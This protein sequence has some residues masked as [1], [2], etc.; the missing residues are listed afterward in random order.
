M[1]KPFLGASQLVVNHLGLKC[2]LRSRA[3]ARACAREGRG[4]YRGPLPADPAHVNGAATPEI[5]SREEP[6]RPNAD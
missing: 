4:Y 6:H 3:L 2:P 1:G 5:G